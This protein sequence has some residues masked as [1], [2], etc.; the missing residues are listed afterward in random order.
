MRLVSE[1]NGGQSGYFPHIDGLRALA[2][3]CVILYH[4]EL[5]LFGGG[6]IGVDVFFVISGYLITAHI[7]QSVRRKEFS[8]RGFYAKRARRL[9][10][11]LFATLLFTLLAGWFIFPAANYDRL[12]TETIFSVFSVSNFL[13]WNESGYFD[14]ASTL[15]PLLHTWSL[16]VEEQFYLFW[17]LLL[18]FIKKEKV[19]FSVLIVMGAAS[20]IAAE[21]LVRKEPALV[22]Y[23]MPFRIVEF[24]IGGVLVWLGGQLRLRAY[25]HEVLCLVGLAAVI[26]PVFLYSESTTFPGFAAVIPCVGAALIILFGEKTY[27]GLCL[28]LRPVVYAGLIS[29]SLYL[30]H[31]P[32]IVLYKYGLSRFLVTDKLLLLLAIF[33]LAVLMYH[34]VETPFRKRGSFAVF[35]PR[36]FVA[37]MMVMFVSLVGVSWVT[38]EK[39]GWPDRFGFEQ[40]T[41]EKIKQGKSDRFQLIQKN[42]QARGWDVCEVPS[43]DFRK[44]VLIL[45]DSHAADALNI[46][47][48]AYPDKYYVK[49][50]L[51]GCPPAV[52]DTLKRIQGDWSNYEE[53]KALNEQRLS[54]EFLG[55]FDTIVIGLYWG[56]YKPEDLLETYEYIQ[57]VAD[58][59]LIVFGNYLA[60][61]KPM[62]DL[63]NQ[64]VD[65]R[66]FT[67]Y[68]AS[69]A[70]FDERLQEL[71]RNRYR[72]LS[73]KSLFCTAESL[74][75]CKIQFG[76]A[77]YSYDQHHLSFEATEFASKR[78]KELYPSWDDLQLNAL[79]H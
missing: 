44:N 14:G 43:E 69:F 38:K 34:F 75:G 46:L 45:G 18:C 33:L 54:S 26:V 3:I 7:R 53:C 63:F 51:G 6:F 78:L 52:G 13:F 41:S 31:W 9:L 40:L 57:D 59:S 1:V 32:L 17:P 23:M 36:A 27:V 64:R 70:L 20:L 48:L 19:V 15:K 24:S 10:P 76:S 35:G 29:Y 71:S 74:S 79:N 21:L 16:S 22:F 77:P 68:V 50:S 2:V 25:T 12:A 55:Q 11:A 47:Q 65:P 60:L 58:A 56:T 73:K 72:Y 28:R 37:A 62:S 42:C 67:D 5:T 66:I 8:F 61:N 39:A 30:V 49:R 4:L